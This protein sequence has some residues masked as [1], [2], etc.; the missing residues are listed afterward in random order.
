MKVCKFGGTSVASAQQIQK[1]TAIIQ[2]DPSRRIVVV[3]APG[4][5]FDGDIKVTDLLISL[6]QAALAGQAVEAP[7][8]RVW[9]RYSEIADGLNLD[10]AILDSIK[11]DLL[12]RLAG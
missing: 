10:G 1:V 4:K 5:R 2:S 3:S 6:G 12:N 11:I 9:E 7:L 8:K